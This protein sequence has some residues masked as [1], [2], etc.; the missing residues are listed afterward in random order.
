MQPNLHLLIM[1]KMWQ[2]RINSKHK[3]V[4]LIWLAIYPLITV[5]FLF[6][7]DYLLRFPLMIRTLILTLI[8]VPLAAYTILPFYNRIFHKWLN[9]GD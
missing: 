6:L 9:S 4:F 1:L 2:M 5:L 7:G 3:R 8:A